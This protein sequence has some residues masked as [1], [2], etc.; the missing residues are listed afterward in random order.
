MRKVFSLV[1]AFLLCLSLC[2]CGVDDGYKPLLEAVEAGNYDGIKAAL[3]G[4]SPDFAAEQAELET[5][6]RY[7][8][9][10]SALEKEDFAA[11]QADL[12]ERIPVP[13]YHT[14]EITQENWDTYFEIFP[15][16]DWC[17]NGFGEAEDYVVHYRFRVKEEYLSD[18]NVNGINLSV[19]LSYPANYHRGSVDLANREVSIGGIVTNISGQPTGNV[20]QVYDVAWIHEGGWFCEVYTFLIQWDDGTQSFYVIEETPTV[21]RIQGTI[22][23]LDK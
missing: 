12:A 20:Q 16:E 22:Q 18:I 3:T 17:L 11:A 19:E 14:V 13:T 1:L 4:L 21:S 15:L 10:I 7:E 23:L 5:Y 8:S 2:A 6:R 9:L